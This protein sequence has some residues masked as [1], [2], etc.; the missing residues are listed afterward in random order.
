MPSHHATRVFFPTT[1]ILLCILCV[2]AVNL[3]QAGPLTPPAGPISPTPGPEPRIAINATNTP[4]DADSLFRIS[5]AGSYYLTGNVT[6]VVGK[7]GIEIA[8]TGVTLDLNGFEV[9]GNGAASAFDGVFSAVT[10]SGVVPVT[11]QNGTIRNWGDDGIRGSGVIVR[12]C[13]LVNNS[14]DGISGAVVVTDCVA[15]GNMGN[16]IQANNGALV[17]NCL[18]R[19]NGDDGI[20]ASNGST[21]TDCTAR[22]NGGYGIIAFGSGLISRCTSSL[23][24]L[25]GINGQQA[26]T[27]LDCN[28][29]DNDA[30][31]ITVQGEC[32]VRGN[33]CHGNG[34]SGIFVSSVTGTRVEGNTVTNNVRGLHITGT[35]TLIIRNTAHGNTT[36][37]W[38]IDANNIVGP[39]INRTA[40]AS[41]SIN[42]DSAPDST[43]STH[44]NANFTY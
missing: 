17:Q 26:T 6:G 32:L 39:I 41:A 10:S 42:G 27:I 15:T 23:N 16:G 18:A 2:S 19:D 9:I 14:G 20:S 21:V 44:P 22:N 25:G 35:N 24:T 36:W 28:A 1:N 34:A 38:D 7:H 43:G 13:V 33:T 31:G 29:S 5:A 8:V 4:G 3:V 40:P 30:S 11:I 37:N 12:H